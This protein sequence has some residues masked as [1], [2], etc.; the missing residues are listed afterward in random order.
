[1]HRQHAM[2]G[3]VKKLSN[4]GK[5]EGQGAAPSEKQEVVRLGV[6]SQCMSH[7]HEPRE[8]SGPA[9]QDL[10]TGNE[11]EPTLGRNA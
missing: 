10:R 3:P 1:M 4:K 7:H 5:I 6:N 9:L 2:R 11:K 8:K